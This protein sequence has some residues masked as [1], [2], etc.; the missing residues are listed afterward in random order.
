MNRRKKDLIHVWLGKSFQQSIVTYTELFNKETKST[1]GPFHC[2]FSTN[3]DSLKTWVNTIHI[4]PK[5]A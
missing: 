3:T 2:G 1:S 4:Y 5:V